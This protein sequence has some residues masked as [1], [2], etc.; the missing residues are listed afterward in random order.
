MVITDTGPSETFEGNVGFHQ[1][2][3]LL[4]SWTLLLSPVRKKR[5]T[6]RVR[7]VPPMEELFGSGT[8]WRDILIGKGLDVNSE[9]YIVMV[10][11]RAVVGYSES[12]SVVSV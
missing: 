3:A 6:L 10:G 11:R 12:A 1:G 8:E 9:K 2:S 4:L 5:Y 7:M